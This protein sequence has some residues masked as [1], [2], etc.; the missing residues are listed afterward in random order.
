MKDSKQQERRGK[1]AECAAAC[2]CA[3]GIADTA[4]ADIAEASGYGEATIYRY[5]SNKE[6]LIMECGINFW[7]MAGEAFEALARE[8]SYRE[9]T[10]I[11]QVEALLV[12]TQEIFEKHRSMF[13]FLHELDGYLA[14]R[15]V[16]SGLLSEYEA[17]VDRAKPLLCEAI[18]KGKRDGTIQ[19][20]THTQELYYTLTHT[21]L[22]LLQKMAGFGNLL[23]GDRLVE[24]G[25]RIR[26]LRRLLLAGLREKDP[27]TDLEA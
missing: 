18:E 13:R 23:P 12:L 3:K 20:T 14:S 22:S 16:E 15:R 10:G 2:F 6:N 27:G 24:E 1:L 26:L 4:I 5:F 8:G 11:G 9:K 7:K 19:C 25:C 21:V 17:Q